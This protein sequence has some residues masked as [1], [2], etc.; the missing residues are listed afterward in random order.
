[1]GNSTLV[2]KFSIRTTARLIAATCV[3][4]TAAENWRCAASESRFLAARRPGCAPIRP[5]GDSEAVGEAR[6]GVVARFLLGERTARRVAL[7][8]PALDAADHGPARVDVVRA[9]Q[10]GAGEEQAARRIEA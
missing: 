10:A 9:E 4:S 7:Q 6:D 3:L 2:E 1:M 5:R 8:A